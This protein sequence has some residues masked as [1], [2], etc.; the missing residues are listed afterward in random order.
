MLSLLTS[1]TLSILPAGFADGVAT[2]ATTAEAGASQDAPE[3]Q[4]VESRIIHVG[5][6]KNGLA[7]VRRAVTLPG[8]GAF[9]VEDVPAPIHGTFWID[10]SADV[11]VRV[12][13]R[14]T[15]TV[16]EIVLTGRIQED[17]AGAVVDLERKDGGV[18][19]GTVLERHPGG[20]G[21]LILETEEG[22]VYLD[23]SLVASL[24]V[25]EAAEREPLTSK[26]ETPVLE[27]TPGAGTEGPLEL[28]ITYLTRGVT[29]TP[30]YRVDIE[31]PD[32]LVVSQ[33]TVI[34]NELTD[35]KD[36]QVE[37]ISG[38]PSIEFAQ[39][40]SP[41]TMGTQLATFFGQLGSASSSLLH[42]SRGDIRSQV[43][44]NV[45]NYSSPQGLGDGP[46]V[47]T[48]D[49]VDM[50]HREIGGHSLAKGDALVLPLASATA[51]YERI[52]EWKIP[53]LRDEWGRPVDDW[54]R[55][56][57]P[58][59]ADDGVWDALRFANP[60]DFPMTTAPALIVD[61]SR[62]NGQRTS[63]WVNPGQKTTLR[64]T[65]AL[66]IR[67]MATELEEPSDREF[68]VIGGRNYRKPVVNGE[69]LVCNHR[70]EP[71]T[72]VIRRAFSGELV[73]SD[74]DPEVRL[75]ESGV[76]N[77]NNRSELVWKITLKPGET[78]TLE[79]HYTVLVRH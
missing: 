9:D 1:F 48:S 59:F 15:E 50:H 38:F 79:Y 44:S 10:S 32:V 64:I 78:R 21:L 19:R 49:G 58:S 67:T 11:S 36:V 24:R 13:T 73:S 25:V 17:L 12:T 30:S 39:V 55:Q 70:G 40:N 31:D 16:E 65:K 8:P 7:V 53:D 27:L 43:V 26:K 22:R 77:I 51:P 46:I 52:V 54:R 34:N 75:L 29:W 74:G 28:E 69:L 76:Y 57:D 18:I 71:T 14:T 62:F 20:G 33:K 66:S 5:L 6:F 41:M 72:V 56:Q 68:V 47:P 45:V 37:L 2:S 35:L 23:P 3:S 61:G 60:F 42:A 63:T 4:T